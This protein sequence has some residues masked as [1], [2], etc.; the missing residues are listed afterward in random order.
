MICHATFNVTC[1]VSKGVCCISLE[2]LGDNELNMPLRY[3]GVELKNIELATNGG[4]TVYAH[5]SDSPQVLPWP[6]QSN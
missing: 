6:C 4:V 3:S 2:F 1:Q 5:K